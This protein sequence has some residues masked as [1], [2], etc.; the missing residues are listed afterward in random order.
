VDG[1]SV[2]PVEGIY[3]GDAHSCT[4]IN[5][6]SLIAAGVRMI[7]FFMTIHLEHGTDDGRTCVRAMSETKAGT[8]DT[9]EVAPTYVVDAQSTVLVAYAP[10]W[11]EAVIL[12]E[13]VVSAHNP[14]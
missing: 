8:S 7:E 11:G 9:E 6:V 10:N 1:S 2:I 13:S 3:T 12:R 14:V 4:K 5:A